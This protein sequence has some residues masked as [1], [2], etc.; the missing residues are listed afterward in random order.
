MLKKIIFQFI[1]LCCSTTFLYAKFL[2]D[3]SGI[4]LTEESFLQ[5]Q[6]KYTSDHFLKVK[7]GFLWSDFGFD[8]RGTIRVKDEKND[9][10]KS[11]LPGSVFGFN[12]NGIKYVYINSLNKYFAI[13]Y[14]KGPLYFFVED[15]ESWGYKTLSTHERLLYSKKLGD[16][17]QVFNKKNILKDFANNQ[18]EMQLL[19]D[20]YSQIKT[21]AYYMGKKQFFQCQKIIEEYMQKF[22]R[23]E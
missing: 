14:E 21:K 2:S 15:Q 18:K 22:N 7:S 11:F 8:V 19:I 13:I 16:P 20:L 23:V 17:L 9:I 3:T 4:Y 1:I 5:N 12:N 6:M 10:F